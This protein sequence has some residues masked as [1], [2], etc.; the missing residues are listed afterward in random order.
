MNFGITP[1]IAW[2]RDRENR[3]EGNALGQFYSDNAAG[4]TFKAGCNVP[5]ND[6]T[7]PFVFAAIP[8]GV[9]IKTTWACN[10]PTP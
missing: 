1:S 8:P 2:T 9:N 3:L 5:A 4:D 10:A 7:K 6:P